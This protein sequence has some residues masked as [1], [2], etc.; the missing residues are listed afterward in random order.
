ME[1]TNMVYFDPAV[2]EPKNDSLWWFIQKRKKKM[3]L[4]SMR[5]NTPKN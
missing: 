2:M 4:N 1:I 3:S 5:G